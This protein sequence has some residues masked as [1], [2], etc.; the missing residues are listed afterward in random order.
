MLVDVINCFQKIRIYNIIRQIKNKITLYSFKLKDK[1]V[2]I[3][4]LFFKKRMLN[5]LTI[6]YIK[7]NKLYIIIK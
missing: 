2:G 1:N 5:F 6:K 7:N 3:W 4:P